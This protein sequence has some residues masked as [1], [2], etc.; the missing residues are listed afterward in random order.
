MRKMTKADQDII[1]GQI[2]SFRTEKFEFD[3]E[4]AKWDDKSNDIIVISKNM[5]KILVAMTD[6]TSGKG[7]L[8]TTSDV[9]TAAQKISEAGI[10]LDKLAR[11]IADQCPES[12]TKK[13]I[14]AYLQRITLHCHQLNITS[15]V[16][17]DVMNLSGELIVQGLDS[18]TSL[19]QAS[20][21][22]M[23]AVILTVKSCYIASSKYPC[24]GTAVGIPI[25][26]KMKAPQKK[27]L[28]RNDKSEIVRVKNCRGSQKSPQN[29]SQALSEL[30][31]HEE[32]TSV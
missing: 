7:P 11:Q 13:D 20:K 6:F 10:K 18:A 25:V 15:K 5:S 21:N 17:A 26:W 2:E 23:N 24:Q 3:Q 14:L 29:R 27:P 32:E 12:E 9:I 22:L 19:I 28:V 1:T 16:K 8:K 4:V 30:Q 31:T